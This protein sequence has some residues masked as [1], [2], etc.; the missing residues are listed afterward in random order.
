MIPARVCR[1]L[2]DSGRLSLWSL[3]D[4]VLA[5]SGDSGR[6]SL[7]SLEDW[8]LADSG[9]S[10]RLRQTLQDWVRQNWP[11]SHCQSLEFESAGV[12]QTP[13]EYVGQCK[14]LHIT[15][16]LGKEYMVREGWYPRA[17]RD[18]RVVHSWPFSSIFHP[19]LTSFLL[20]FSLH[21]T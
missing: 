4:W 5:D 15:A 1:S 20:S 13:A 6:L 14:V 12:R 16:E 21:F 10:G 8:V 18:S 3:E 11:M 17:T 19:F 2:A 9:D 7:W